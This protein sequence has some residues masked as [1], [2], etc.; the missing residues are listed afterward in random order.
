[1]DGPL[2]GVAPEVRAI[3][4]QRIGAAT[5]IKPDHA[6]TRSTPRRGLL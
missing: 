1:V 5:S 4:N 3:E 6:A 2:A